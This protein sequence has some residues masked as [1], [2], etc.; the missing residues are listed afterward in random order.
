MTEKEEKS[1][2]RIKGEMLA[3]QKMGERLVGLSPVLIEKMDLPPDLKEAVFLA[4]GLNKRGARRR[5]LQYIGS[6]MRR[7][8]P[9]PIREALARI[10][11]GQKK[12]AWAFQQ[13]EQWRDRLIGGDDALIDELMK[14]FPHTNRQQLR[15]LTLSARKEKERSPKAARAL[16]RYL[17]AL[18]ETEDSTSDSF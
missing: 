12:E 7:V 3:L 4:R 17:R 13:T 5:Q 18:L 16:F 11:Q 2:S 1:R 10:D 6:L 9:E 14:R 8:N 15:R